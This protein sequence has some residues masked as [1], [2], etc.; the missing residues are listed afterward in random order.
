MTRILFRAALG[1]QLLVLA[2]AGLPLK[3]ARNVS[4]D[5]SNGV[6][7]LRIFVGKDTATYALCPEGKCPNRVD[8][9]TRIFSVPFRRVICLSSVHAGFLEALNARDRVVGV[10]NANFICDSA[11]RVLGKRGVWSAVGSDAQVDWE[12]V[13]SLRSDALLYSY[14]PGGVSPLKAKARTLNVNALATA[15][16]LENHPLGRAEWLRVY[17]VLLGKERLADSL[18]EQVRRNY[19]SLRDGL[20]TT[21]RP[22]ALGGL[23]WRGQWFVPGGASYAAQLLRDAGIHYLWEEDKHTGGLPLSL[24]EVL[25]KSRDADLWINPGEAHS[26]SGLLALEPRAS[27]FRS[28]REGKVY[29]NDAKLCAEG[30][31]LYWESAVT[32]PDLLLCDF[33]SAASGNLDSHSGNYFRRLP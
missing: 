21:R 17:G 28:Y 9:N 14:P 7:R 24:E 32:H 13:L 30:G 3:Y 12:R 18:F 26:L 25:Q 15:E 4:L 10:D 6:A 8:G 31:N 5:S 22:T 2:V 20:K 29:Q 33:A 23:G 1:V 11:L 27:K 16:W 19:E